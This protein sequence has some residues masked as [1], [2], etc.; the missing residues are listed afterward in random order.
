MDV[1]SRIKKRELFSRQEAAD[2]L[3]TTVGTLAVWK[4]TGRYNLKTVKVG[5]LVKY[6]YSDLLDFIERNTQS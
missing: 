4:S 6:R 2:F 3:G 5:R 1:E